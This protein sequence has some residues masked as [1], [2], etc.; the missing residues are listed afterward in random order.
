M[1]KIYEYIKPINNRCHRFAIE[2]HHIRDEST[3]S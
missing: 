2:V 1:Y 3:V